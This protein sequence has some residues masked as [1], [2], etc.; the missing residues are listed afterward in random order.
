MKK[1]LNNEFANVGYDS[2][3]N[4]IITVWKKPTTSEAYR[5]IFS[6]ML[7]KLLEFKAEAI[8]TDI[9]QQ[10]IVSTENRLWLQNEIIPKAYEYGLRKVGTISPNDVFSKFYVESVKNG[11]LVNSIDLAFSYFND[12]VS[13]QEWVLQQEIAA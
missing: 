3:S 12:L 6:L 5:V 1:I 8:I 10:G 2:E 7:E 11:I 9:Y 13:A 4:A